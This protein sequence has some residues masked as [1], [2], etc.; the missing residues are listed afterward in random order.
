MNITRRDLG[1]LALAALP[2]SQLQAKPDSKFGGVQIS[3]NAPYSFRG[4]PGGADDV[5]GYCTKLGL[6]SVELRTQP[7]EAFLGAP[8]VRPMPRGK[9]ADVSS[10]Q[11]AAFAKATE[12][13]QSW[14]RALSMDKIKGFRKKYEDAGV[15]I[16]IVKVDGIDSMPDDILDYFFHVAKALGGRAI[17]CEPPLSTTER[18]GKFAE[19]HKF[20]VGYHGHTNITD[21]EAFGG[22]TSWERSMAFSKFNGI[23]LDIGHFVAGNNVSPIEY[24]K[25]HHAKITHLHIKDRKKNNG[26]NTAFGQADTPIVEVL[27]LLKKEKYPFPATIEFE[28]PT[29]AGSDVLTEIGKAVEFCKQALS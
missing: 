2:V 24:I 19:K 13:L 3:I 27:Q 23:N 20:M 18:I 10:E 7:V 8:A 22:P 28:Y 15:K 16:Q 6:S 12:E 26:P 29:P 5:L 14:R 11:R 9:K 17:S 25:K 1:K 4:L 21:P